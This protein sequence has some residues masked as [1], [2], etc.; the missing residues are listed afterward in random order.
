MPAYEYRCPN[1]D[2]RTE[3][4]RSIHEEEHAPAC[5]KCSE[6]MKKVFASPAINLVGRGFYRNGG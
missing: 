6:E 1:C 5:G 2:E 3:V 4:Q